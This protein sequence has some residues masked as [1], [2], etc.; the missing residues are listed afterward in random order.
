MAAGLVA[1]A[2]EQAAGG[3][4]ARSLDPQRA[5]EQAAGA[6]GRAASTRQRAAAADA[7]EGRRRLA[8]AAESDFEASRYALWR[9]RV[10]FHDVASA[11]FYMSDA[12]APEAQR[13]P[14]KQIF[15]GAARRVR[16][17]AQRDHHRVLLPPHPR[18]RRAHRHRLRRRRTRGG[19]DR[20]AAAPAE[21]GLLAAPEGRPPGA[22]GGRRAT[23]TAPRDRDAPALALVARAA[24]PSRRAGHTPVPASPRCARSAPTRPPRSAI[25][26]EPTFGDPA[27]WKAKEILFHC[28]HLH[29][30]ALEFLTPQPRK[31]C[32]RMIFGVIATL[33]GTLDSQRHRAAHRP[34]SRS[35]SRRS[36]NELAEAQRYYSRRPAPGAARVLRRA[37]WF[38]VLASARRPDRDPRGAPATA[39]PSAGGEPDRGRDRR[40]GE[41]ACRA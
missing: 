23:R 39:R 4:R 33:L 6:K 10:T 20:R 15:P 14:F 35:S 19:P 16:G 8:M 28:L 41:R 12:E 38:L 25:H 9:G 31:I 13:E 29:Y 5:D 3:E 21:A 1:R 34:T 26:I 18:R 11:W 27:D 24:A 37:C 36:Q 30:R 2:D 22:R 17:A 32:M 7:A 40:R